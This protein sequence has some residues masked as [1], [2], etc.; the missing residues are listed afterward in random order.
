MFLWK[1]LSIDEIHC[2]ISFQTPFSSES[3]NLRWERLSKHS[4][5]SS[6][7]N[8]FLYHPLS[9]FCHFLSTYSLEVTIKPNGNSQLSWVLTVKCLQKTRWGSFCNLVP[10][11]NSALSLLPWHWAGLQMLPFIPYLLCDFGTQIPCSGSFVPLIHVAFSSIGSK[12][13]ISFTHLNNTCF[14]I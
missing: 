6:S 9:L 12:N 11:S 5:I 2:S 10:H 13:F 14:P 4:D 8:S 1:L 3:K 7:L